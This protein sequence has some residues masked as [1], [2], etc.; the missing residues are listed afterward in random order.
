VSTQF[1]ILGPIA[2]ESGDRGGRV[3]RGRTLSLLALLLVNRG[4]IVHV[5]RAV[6]ELWGGADPQ[7]GRKAVQVLASRLRAALDEGVLVTEGGGYALRPPAASLDADRFEALLRRGREELAGGEREEAAAT[8]RQ[9]L[10]LWRGPAL[11]DVAEA[12]FAQPEITRLETLRLGCL[13]DRIDADLACGRHEELVGEL[14]ALVQQHPYDER[15]RGR[16]MLALYH[17]GRQADALDA[18]RAAYEALADGLG[19]EPS[20]ELRSLEAAILRHEVPAPAA[21]QE[22]PLPPDV[23][24]RVTCV[25]VRPALAGAD[26][27]SLRARLEHDRELASAA[28][29]RH[30]GSVAEVRGE[31][32]LL[33]FG[34][35]RAHEDDALRALRASLELRGDTLALGVGTGDVVAPLIGEAPAAAERQARAAAAGEIRIDEPTWRLVR[36][37]ARTSKLPGGAFLLTDLDADTPAIMRRL[38]RPLV[39]RDEELARLRATFERVVRQRAPALLTIRGEPGIGKSR[40]AAELPALVGPEGRVLTGRCPS[41]GEGVTYWPLREMVDQARG[42]RTMDALAASLGVEPPVG[43]LVAAAV[44]LAPG[45]AGDDPGWAFTRLIAALARAQPLVMVVDDAHLAEPALLELLVAV[46]GRIEDAPVL[47]VWVARPDS[48]AE[49]GEVLELGPLSDAASAALLEGSRLERDERVHVARAAG[50]NPLFLEQLVAYLESQ[51]PPAPAGLLPPAL[52]AL[53]A[54][55]LDRLGDGERSA[56]AYGAIVGDAF[57]LEPVHALADDMTRAALE[58]AWERLVDLDLL[59][60]GDGDAMRFRHG[61]V[62]EAAY[63]ALTK[64]VR[65]RLHERHAAWLDDLGGELPEA[66]ARIAFHL[67]SACRYQRGLTGASAPAL[68]RR[69]GDRLAAAARVARGRGDLLGEIGFLDRAVALLGTES[70]QGAALLPVLLWALCDAGASERA[71]EVAERAVAAT[72]A[73]ALAVAGARSAIER[74]RIRLYRHPE[75]FDVAAAMATVER[76]SIPL[77]REHDELGLA[78]AAYLLSDVTWLMGDTVRSDGEAERM[79]GHARR[80]GSAFDVGTALIFLAWGLVE[81]PLPAPAA[82]ARCDALAAEAAG[83]RGAELNLRGCRAVLTA[84][85]GRFDE[86]RETMAEARA[87]FAELQLGVI[88][89]YLALLDGIA[90]TL[91]GNHAAAERAVRDAEAMISGSETRWY[92]A[93]IY[94]DIAHAVLAQGR[95][96]DAAAA[97]ARIETLPAPCDTEWSIKRHTARALLAARQGNPERGLADARAAVAI[98]DATGLMICRANAHRTLAELLLAGG[99]PQDAAASALRALALDEAKGNTVAAANTR[100]RFAELL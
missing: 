54:A 36:H 58:Q 27:E 16:Q 30:G 69:A 96:D 81:G 60:L 51:G 86:A 5:D 11:A 64:S 7:H 37:G 32:L 63:A 74:E 1:R 21:P 46:A 23:R 50:G 95:L 49:A 3:P 6:D 83:Q 62:R 47:I 57:E 14:E 26:P 52:H 85:T 90:E 15:L 71:E 9:A 12:R 8:L 93:F 31:E 72:A 10:A 77:R 91:A 20:P 61:L 99:R 39:G 42:E 67:E 4:S 73:Q 18:Y 56:L 44:G 13:A 22:P 70:E 33:A 87:G 29:A 19:I 65:A 45:R 79:L 92:E 89:A 53:L 59:E 98:G 38:D 97:V 76:A 78:R 24:R 80:A 88:A 55:R 84:M 66:D 94:A 2:V 28:C 43:H 17:A 41:Y 48:G 25:V 75:Y 100:L 40:L 34:T 35:P 68:L 82:I